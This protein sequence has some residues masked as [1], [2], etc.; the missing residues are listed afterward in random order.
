MTRFS[1]KQ[2]LKDDGFRQSSG[3][4]LTLSG[5]T[6]IADSG[7]IAYISCIHDTYT[8]RSLVDKEYVDKCGACVGVEPQVIF[9]D[10]DGITGATGFTYDKTTQ[11]VTIPNLSISQAPLTGSSSF[12]TPYILTW[13]DY[14]CEVRRIP[15]STAM[16]L[17][18]AENGLTAIGTVV[19]LG[20]TLCEDTTISGNDAF[21][22]K[23][24]ELCESCISTVSKNI[25][26]DAQ[27]SSGIVLKS[28]LGSGDTDTDFTNA[29][30]INIDYNKPNEFKIYDNRPILERHGI[31]YADDYSI[32]YTPR[33]LVD[34]EYVDAIATGIIP[35]EA[36]G[37]ATT[38]SIDIEATSITG[39]TIDN[40][41]IGEGVRVLVKN[42][43]DERENGIYEITGG[44][45][46]R[47]EDFPTGQTT[48]V[49]QGISTFVMS[50]DTNQYSTWILV[51]P[52]P[53]LVA[54]PPYGTGNTGTDLIFMLFSRGLSISEGTGITI[55][56]VSGLQEISVAGDSLSGN[57]IIW[58]GNTFNVDV[59]SIISLGVTGGTNGI[60][61]IGQDVA[62]G[63]TLTGDTT[64][65]GGYTLNYGGDYS[66]S[67]TC[68]SLVDVNYVTGITSLIE[69]DVINLY[70][71]LN[72]V[73]VDITLTGS[74][75]E[76]TESDDFIGVSGGTTVLLP[77]PP[78]TGQR[79]TVAD[80]CG[81]AND[82][83][84]VI[85][86][87]NSNLIIDDNTACVNTDYGAIMFVFNNS[88]FWSVAGFVN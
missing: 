38:E 82:I 86:C 4:T 83:T 44:T 61:L 8:D 64:F 68:H 58:S 48:L 54:S 40:V 50:G 32:N 70:D 56:N 62:L 1:T 76:A 35:K 74:T 52:D 79:I 20:G 88:G 47:T 75:Y 26:L 36:V 67:F 46:V 39:I 13:D 3:Q 66:G 65:D 22:L 21:S 60:T 42:Q 19:K 33:S 24:L 16:G 71:L 10:V 43:I 77:N 78:K 80:I 37:V 84:P 72:V 59:D 11:I 41:L 15:A 81:N 9:R 14:S 17:Q 28:Q 30:G 29:I 25:V 18:T 31:E 45:W 7:G 34:K 23:L 49:T 6:F 87:G 55:N 57:Y 51:S 69:S 2:K 27:N 53:I 12:G 63:G 73:E 5:N 85:I